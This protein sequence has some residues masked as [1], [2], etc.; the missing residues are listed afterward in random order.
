MESNFQ[1]FQTA[2]D[3]TLTEIRKMFHE[4]YS[5]LRE[6]DLLSAVETVRNMHKLQTEHFKSLREG[7]N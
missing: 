5:N 3:P 7:F 2:G 6:K 1:K 4:F